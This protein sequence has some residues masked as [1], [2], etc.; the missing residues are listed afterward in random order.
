MRGI[1]ENAEI[2]VRSFLKDTHKKRKGKPLQ[3]VDYMDEGTPIA[4]KIVIDPD[5]GGAVFDFEGTGPEGNHNLNAPPAVA[6]SA[7][8][9]CLRVLIGID[10]PLNSGCL[11]PL[12]IKIPPNTIISPSDEAAVSSGNTECSQRITDVVFK[13]FEACAASQSVPS[14]SSIIVL[15]S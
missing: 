11:N 9:Y 1:L 7:I 2:A 15:L 12:D 10:I 4:L 6:K 8:L 5:T 14:L 3:A 13:A